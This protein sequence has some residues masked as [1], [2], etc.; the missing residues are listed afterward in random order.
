MNNYGFF[1]FGFSNP[2]I[3]NITGSLPT[4]RSFG[5]I[6]NGVTDDT[7]AIQTALNSGEKY[8]YGEGLNY[9]VSSSLTMNSNT[10]LQDCNIITS[11]SFPINSSVFSCQGTLN[12]SV[13]PSADI[14]E[15][16]Y[17]ISVTDSSLFASGD[18]IFIKS[19]AY[20]SIASLDNV[21]YGEIIR[22]ESI[23]AGIL[24][25]ETPTLLPYTASDSFTISK[26]NT[27]S[28]IQLINVSATGIDNNLKFC[29]F[30]YA[31]NVYIFGG[32]TVNFDN[33][34]YSFDACVNYLVD[35]VNMDKS[36][37]QDGLNY[38]VIH[39]SGCVNGTVRDS[40]SSEMR[41][42]S[43]I[44]GS[45]GI[46]RSINVVGCKAFNM[47]DAG[48]DA[49]SAVYEHSF[50]NNEIIISNSS[51]TTQ[52]GIIS[53]GA[54]PIITG[55]R[56]LNARRH[57][58]IW[59]PLLNTNM[60]NPVYA[61]I[62]GNEIHYNQSLTGTSYAFFMTTTANT[63]RLIDSA[64]ISENIVSGN[65]VSNTVYVTCAGATINNLSISNNQFF[66]TPVNRCIQL[67]S[68][69]AK[70]SNIIIIG[71]NMKSG[72]AECV[73]IQGNVTFGIDNV[74]FSSNITNGGT[75]GLRV[76]Y[77]N[78]LN[79]VGNMYLNFT[80]ANKLIQNTTNQTNIDI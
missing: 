46:A 68:T 45:Q 62:E 33:A 80:T 44:G 7:L 75:Y 60:S 57:G 28:N 38:G 40:I 69:S 1:N 24:N 77:V 53:Q 52:D 72:V 15:G 10:S 42:L 20:W 3:V 31:E 39:I 47:T 9:L 50:I 34:H 30:K 76:N 4:L 22:I 37:V 78:Y 61:L 67:V 43:S 58:I 5:A 16:A 55:N 71:N 48:I 6:G 74:M 32:V 11:N 36:G 63:T 19:N 65:L 12:A 8:L 49:H 79:L 73:Y 41:H 56:I 18:L 70:I 64:V 29:S 51:D 26:I 17:S 66:N 13:I 2:P 35:N 14:S 25:L 21:K 27:K 59:Q 23:G 54:K